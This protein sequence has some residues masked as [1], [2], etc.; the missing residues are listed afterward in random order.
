MDF[1]WDPAKNVANKAKHG[2]GFESFTGWDDEAIVIPD[3]RFDYGE[4][5]LIA[6]GRIDGRPHAMVYTKR[7]S[8]TRLISFRRAREEEI[9]RYE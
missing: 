4:P 9:G 5:R 7:E 2:I 8:T 1:E 6:F 3:D